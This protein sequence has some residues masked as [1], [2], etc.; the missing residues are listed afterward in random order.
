MDKYADESGIPIGLY[1]NGD[2][3][4]PVYLD[5]K[6]L[7][8]PEAAHLNVTGVSGLATKTSI[9]EF[10]MSSIFQHYKEDGGIASGFI[11]C[12]RF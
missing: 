12:K 5:S 7:I 6:F 8:G 10:L 2:N 1:I 4:S 9:I 11:Q 3:Q